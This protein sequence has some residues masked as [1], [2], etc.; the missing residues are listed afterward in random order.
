MTL[1][2]AITG[3]SGDAGRG[4]IRGLRQNP[5]NSEPIWILG[6]DAATDPKNRSLVDHFLRVPLVKEPEY[7]DA[8]AEALRR[9]EI[10]VLLP[11]IDSEIAVLSAARQRFMS[12]GT[13]L[14]LPPSELA[15]VADD[16]LLTA[17]FLSARG[18]EVPVTCG[19]ESPIDI[20]FPLVAK[21]RRGHGS[22]GIAMI[23]DERA[24]QAFLQNLPENYCLQR[25]IE[26]PEITVGLLY[27]STGVIRDAIAMERALENG[28]TVRARVL[29]DA[30]ILEFVSHLAG[31][32]PGIGAIN[33]QL[34]WHEKEGPMVFEINARLSGSTE[35]RVAVGF[36]DP[37]RLA[38]H[39]GRGKPIV[40][41]QPLRAIV[42]R[43]TADL[44]V[45]PC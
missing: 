38:F 7:V 16:K 40:A 23:S 21:P 31:K 22:S 5:S 9:H 20:G 35:M 30:I 41:A 33:A 3:I 15:E 28:R 6:L 13:K 17:R 2:V 18:I 8:M 37:L 14:I 29:D 32:V 4:A 1:R 19:A 45:E 26:G 42:H 27:D 11:A 12:T 25:Y 24:L 44:L 34:R 39:F 43:S 10:D 36:N